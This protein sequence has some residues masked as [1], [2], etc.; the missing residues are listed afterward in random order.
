[1]HLNTYYDFNIAILHIF[2]YF[3]F[4]NDRKRIH[5]EIGYTNPK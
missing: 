5:V 3:K 1:M 2:K 4:W